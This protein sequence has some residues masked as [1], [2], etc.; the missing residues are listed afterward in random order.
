MEDDELAR[1]AADLRLITREQ[2]DEAKSFAAG[3]R[4][5]LS[6]LLDLGYL[7][8]DQLPS[9]IDSSP[10]P[11]PPRRGWVWAATLFALGAAG[12]ILFMR[13]HA[14]APLPRQQAPLQH[15]MALAKLA[16]ENEEL[17]A[18]LASPD[19]AACEYMRLRG[20]RGLSEAETRLKDTDRLTPGIR[21]LFE[22]SAALLESSF[23]RVTPGDEE[24]EALGCAREILLEW[25]RALESYKRALAVNPRNPRAL[26]GAARAAL[27]LGMNDEALVYGRASTEVSP[28]GE[29]YLIMGQAAMRAGRMD[30]A[31]RFII[32]SREIDPS[33]GP[34]AAN[35]LERLSRER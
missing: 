1:R 5:M 4:S 22:E 30:E 31:R 13:P 35:L 15:A 27:E 20:L 25:D 17:R 23:E 9:L 10:P 19:R 2:Y 12:A 6:V 11:R 28:T 16:E 7:R 32:K 21:R 29:A 8:A 3:G 26:R 18:R 24:L 34:S 33:L 14:E